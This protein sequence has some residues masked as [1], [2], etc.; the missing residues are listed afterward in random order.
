MVQLFEVDF[1]VRQSI[2]TCFQSLI[3]EAQRNANLEFYEEV[4]FQLAFC[5]KLGFGVRKDENECR[6][7]LYESKRH[8]SDL[9]HQLQLV[10]SS[11]YGRRYD[12][13]SRFGL[14]FGKG[15]VPMPGDVQYYREKNLLN[16]IHSTLEN[17]ISDWKTVLGGTHWMVLEREEQ[18]F[19]ILR[20]LGH[21]D[22]AEDLVRGTLDNLGAELPPDD[23]RVLRV[24]SNVAMAC[25]D[26][27]K[28]DDAER[29][30]KEVFEVS[31]G[32][33]TAR[34]VHQDFLASVYTAQGKFAKAIDLRSE[35]YTKLSAMLGENHIQ[36]LRA[37]W[38]LREDY[39]RRGSVHKATKLNHNLL[40]TTTKALGED[41]E[42]AILAKIGLAEIDW[43]I[44]RW[45]WGY[46]GPR[47]KLELNLDLVSKSQR[48]LG[49][50]HPTTL[51]LMS[52]TAKDLM[53]KT[54]IPEAIALGEQI[55]EFS[56][57][58]AG[59]D[60]PDTVTRQKSLEFAKAIHRW[61]LRFERIGTF[62]FGKYVIT[63]SFGTRSGLEP[64]WGPIFKRTDTRPILPFLDDAR[65][66][67]RNP[68]GNQG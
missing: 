5:Y 52:H 50:E 32:D 62:R 19:H 3:R 28:T 40:E 9:E 44:R 14:W 39:F 67:D 36:T 48:I 18:F 38:N 63:P 57:R 58:R 60:H 33:Q 24:Q 53:L 34:L 21:W 1:R 11:N 37:L 30:I 41:H 51:Q 22:K 7:W 15:H 8:E 66:A 35:V 59:A 56:I 42:L 13:A 12:P 43:S 31:V 29:L 55:V 17:E 26:R 61:Y 49:D 65:I 47:R 64:V 23:F 25:L 45:L 4:G 10:K 2:F 6:K 54:H 16:D 20:S 68:D 46:F 27:R